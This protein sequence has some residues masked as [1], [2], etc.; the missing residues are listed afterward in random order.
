MRK[1]LFFILLA[2]AFVSC[3]KENIHADV[4]TDSSLFAKWELR[5]TD[6]G[7]QPSV[8]YTPGNGN[9][10]QLSSDSTYK[11]FTGGS[12]SKQGTFHVEEKSY[13]TG[14][15]SFIYY[16]HAENGDVFFM[17][18]DSLVIGTS[19]ADGLS[20]VYVRLK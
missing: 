10:V 2:M 5:Q 12:V 17:K 18:N 19:A 1:Q 7:L 11:F 15:F 9:I 16:D 8:V 20:S 3:K 4:K 14:S 6:G 13:P